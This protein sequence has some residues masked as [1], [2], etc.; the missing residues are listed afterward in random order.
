MPEPQTKVIHT[1]DFENSKIV[2]CGYCNGTKYMLGKP[3]TFC[4]G[5]GMLNRIA[6]GT[7]KLYQLK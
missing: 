7:V 1:Q 2:I 5:E 6:S 4:G 3:C